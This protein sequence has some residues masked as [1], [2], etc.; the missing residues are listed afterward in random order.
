MAR[1]AE[2]VI[3]R[4]VVAFERRSL[5]EGAPVF[6]ASSAEVDMRE[7]ERVARDTKWIEIPHD[8]LCNN[9]LAPAFMTPEA[10]AW[11][12][13]AYLI[14]SVA[15]YSATDTLTTTLITCL[16]PPDEVDADQFNSL[17]EDMRGLD[18]D[19]HEDLPSSLGADD[20]LLQLLMERANMLT[21]DEK[22]AV[23]DYLEYIDAT[24]G[25]DFPAFGPKQALDR[26]WATVTRR[27]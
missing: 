9:P 7:I 10:F 11:F 20:E 5:P 24:H 13:P 12:L 14:M 23:R 26:Y 18:V 17:V 25:S 1:T 2:E 22:A 16:T 4:I 19:V 8:V 6:R 27:S 15:L 3:Q 21:R